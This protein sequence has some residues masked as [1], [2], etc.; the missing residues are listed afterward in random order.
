MLKEILKTVGQELFLHFMLTENYHSYA[1]AEE[2][3]RLLKC[4]FFFQETMMLML[5]EILKTGSRRSL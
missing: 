5:K 2:P 1:Q 4:N 3:L